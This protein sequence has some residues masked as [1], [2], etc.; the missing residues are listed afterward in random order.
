MSKVFLSYFSTDESFASE[1]YSRLTRD[2]L[3][4]FFD[5]KSIPWGADWMQAITKGLAESDYI[6]PILTPDYCSSQ[7]P[8]FQ[9]IAFPPDSA[10]DLQKKIRPLLLKECLDVLP[11]M[12]KSMQFMDVSSPEK[13]ATNYPII[14]NSLSTSQP[15]PPAIVKEKSLP[16]GI[17]TFHKLI[18]ENYIYVDK[19][20]Y[21]YN[22][23]E[24]GGPF[25]L[26]RPRRFGKSLLISTLK[27][28]CQ[29]NRDLF[30]G[31]W[32]YHRIPWQKYPVIHLDFLEIDYKRLGL[33]KAIENALNRIAG[34][35]AVPLQGDSISE[36][37][38]DLIGKLSKEKPVV[39]LIDEYDKPLTDYMDDLDQAEANRE[40]LKGIYAILKS[41]QENIRLLFMT[42]VS[43][44]SR[45]SI[46]SDL[47]HLV[48]ITFHPDYVPI[49]GYTSE[50]VYAYFSDYIQEYLDATPKYSPEVLFKKLKEYYNGYSWD[51][52][53]FVY[54]P[55]SIMNFF[56]Q[57]KFKSF[58][59]ATGTPTFLA[60][61]V[62]MRGV[63]VRGW[64]ELEVDDS[65]FDKFD[66]ANMDTDLLLFQTGYLTIKKYENETYTLSYPNREVEHAFLYNLVEEFSGQKQAVS[67]S[68][69]LALR[70]ALENNNI[71]DF[72]EKMKTFLAAIPYTLVTGDVE[73][74]Y[75]LVFYLVLKLAMGKVNPEHFSNRGRMDMVVETDQYIY[76]IE[77]KME[78]AAKALKQIQELG[79]YEQ[80]L[81]QSKKIFL[82]GIGF[83]SEKRNIA[84]YAQREITSG[85]KT[86]KPRLKAKI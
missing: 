83:S 24:K 72:I 28:I 30:K 39:I 51:G 4:C 65:F 8:Q 37:F 5:K 20:Q 18:T 70:K 71:K 73:K 42:G 22:I 31:T 82:I 46:F 14:C 58:W 55:I 76:V 84:D 85:Q 81:A 67:K 63:D 60:K 29:G 54:N 13:F 10:E 35:F 3:E 32:I 68:M 27:E 19:T 9:E 59:F 33:E 56:S 34:E 2:G 69:G 52:E 25:F 40:T 78:S 49:L 80:F 50:E 53:T 61:M 45:L 44:F 48:D 86:K 12:L 64:D 11:P 62:R 41:Q 43:R 36:K 7:W 66:I 74:Y 79:Y 77:F 15:E 57:K 38:L 6:V 1:L 17:S 21:I 26:S 23:V 16:L 47:N 75:H